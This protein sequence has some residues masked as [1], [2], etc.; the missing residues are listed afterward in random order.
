MCRRVVV[1]WWGVI[2]F[3]PISLHTRHSKHDFQLLSFRRYQMGRWSA[4]EMMCEIVI[5]SSSFPPPTKKWCEDKA[6]FRCF[7]FHW[8]SWK[9]EKR[10]DKRNT[11][12]V[13]RQNVFSFHFIFFDFVSFGFLSVSSDKEEKALNEYRTSEVP[14]DWVS[15][16]VMHIHKSKNQKKRRF[17]AKRKWISEHQK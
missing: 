7:R 9:Y 11:F 1:S 4:K 8:H 16:Q 10:G 17:Q 14:T 3:S 6:K 2:V 13:V 15:Y 5:E 12:V